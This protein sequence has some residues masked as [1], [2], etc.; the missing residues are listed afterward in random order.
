MYTLMTSSMSLASVVLL[1]N[2]N[3]ALVVVLIIL[4][5]CGCV[6]M[7]FVAKWEGSGDSVSYLVVFGIYRCV[8]LIS[9]D[10]Q[11]QLGIRT[12]ITTIVLKL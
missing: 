9:G 5:N 3:T 7:Y 10:E 1:E 6:C 4:R 2:L 12:A 11:S 8:A